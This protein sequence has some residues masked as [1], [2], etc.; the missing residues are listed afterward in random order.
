MGTSCVCPLHLANTI[1]GIAAHHCY[2]LTA[3]SQMKTLTAKSTRA[4]L[5]AAYPEA[6]RALEEREGEL[7]TRQQ[8]L[9]DLRNRWSIH[10]VEFAAA[11]R[12][13]RDAGRFLRAQVDRVSLPDFI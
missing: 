13:A 3:P 8:Y 7:I 9:D 11:C 1:D 12:D 4:E 6:K 10:Q 2:V 5:F